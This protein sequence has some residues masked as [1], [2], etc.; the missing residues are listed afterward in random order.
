MAEEKREL[1]AKVNADL[2]K[3]LKEKDE[4]RLSVLRMMKSKVLYVNARGDLSDPEI[5][6][7][8]QSLRKNRSGMLRLPAVRPTIG[9]D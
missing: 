5:T 8:T 9:R 6:A 1:F 2:Q 4:L 3:A 7:N